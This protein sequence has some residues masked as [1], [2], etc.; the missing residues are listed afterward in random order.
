M[1]WEIEALMSVYQSPTGLWE[2]SNGFREVDGLHLDHVLYRAGNGA[3]L[4]PFTT[5]VD[6]SDT[7]DWSMVCFK[8]FF[9]RPE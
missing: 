5:G 1:G 4:T 7:L 6:R 9:A 2:P 8:R 3:M